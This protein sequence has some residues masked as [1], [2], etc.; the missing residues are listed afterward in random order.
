[1]LPAPNLDDRR[2]QDLVDDAKRLVQQRCPEWTDH[3]VSDP[4]VT[5]IETFAYMT[6][7][8]LYR[9]NRVPDRLYIKFLEL[10]G[11]RLLPPTPARVPVTFWLATPAIN[12]IPIQ[13]G[14][15]VSTIRTDLDES[16]S[17]SVLDELLIIPCALDRVATEGANASDDDADDPL[18]WT[19]RTDQL[20][21][22]VEFSAFASPPVPGDCLYVALTDAVPSNAVALQVSCRID[23]VG[24]DPDNPP[25]VWEAWTGE[26]WTACELERDETGGLNRDGQTVVHVP[27]GH[28]VSVLHEQRGGWLRARILEADEG[29]PTYSASP[30]IHGLGGATIGGTAECVHADLV[31]NEAVGESDGTPG[32]VFRTLRSPVLLGGAPVLLQTTSDEGWQDWTEVPD[33]ADSGPDDRHFVFDAVHGEIAL[34][35]AIRLPGGTYDQHGWVPPRGTQLRMRSYAVG[36]GRTGNVARHTIT[37]LRTTIPYIS[38]VDNRYP[39]QG[40]VEGETLEEAKARGPIV[41][42][43]R[44]RA[45]TAE[46]YELLTKQAV[47]EIARVKCLTAGEGPDAGSVKVLIVPAVAGDPA[48]IEFEQLLLDDEL[49]EK[50]RERL[51]ET[52][53]IGTRVLIEPPMYQGVTVVAKLLARPRFN[54]SRVEADCIAALFGFLNPISGGPDGDGWP[55]GRPLQVG[56]IYSALQKVRG[57]DIVD[58]VRLFGANPVTRERGE[59]TQRIDLDPASIVFSFDHQVRVQAP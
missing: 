24:V 20:K 31:R 21:L 35:P 33:F 16:L 55:W 14:T 39:A 32:Q 57:V 6:D 51:E 42:R 34:G 4:G 44:S 8:L 47:P 36:G 50:V 7:Q 27:S 46:D 30:I 18:A 43:T 5:L 52:R 49:L 11:V 13:P 45:V 56:E 23:G 1:M 58:D 28:T 54:A 41:L 17:F 10:I 9:L 59:S 12:V 40:G 26:E 53:L 29:Q 22:G 38:T 48:S 15:E 2:F 37:L 25:L 19:D 3:N